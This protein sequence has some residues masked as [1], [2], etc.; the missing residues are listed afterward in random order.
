MENDPAPTPLG[1][2]GC[3]VLSTR[4]LSMTS[5]AK[6]LKVRQLVLC[7]AIPQWN[8]VVYIPGPHKQGGGFLFA[9]F[10]QRMLS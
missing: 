5:T 4:L 1:A 6:R 7:P 2:A 9:R 3:R 10:A 8:H